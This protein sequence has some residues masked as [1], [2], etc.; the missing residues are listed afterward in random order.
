MHINVK[1]KSNQWS[2]PVIGYQ[3]GRIIVVYADKAKEYN[4]DLSVVIA[5]EIGHYLGFRHYDRGHE[6]K[7]TAKELG[8]KNYD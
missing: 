8:G 7:G 2:V 5:H 1:E 4:L 6:I 3:K